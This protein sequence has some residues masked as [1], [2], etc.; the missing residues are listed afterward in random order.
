[1]TNQ[2]KKNAVVIIENDFNFY[3][4]SKSQIFFC[5]DI[6]SFER[7]LFLEHNKGSEIP[8][9]ETIEELV[10]EDFELDAIQMPEKRMNVW[11]YHLDPRKLVSSLENIFNCV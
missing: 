9:N 1:M 8:Y 11:I 6:T 7:D 2:F 4:N 5:E 3:G 10:N